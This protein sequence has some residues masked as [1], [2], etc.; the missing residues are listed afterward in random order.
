M[1]VVTAASLLGLVVW[2]NGC[3]VVPAYEREH[4]SHPTMQPTADALQAR[5]ERK[6]HQSRE[7]ASGGDAEAAGGGCGCSN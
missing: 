4:L 6:L 3:V 1:R 7:G 5:S 2:S